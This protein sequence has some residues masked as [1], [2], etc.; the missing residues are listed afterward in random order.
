MLIWLHSGV[1]YVLTWYNFPEYWPHSKWWQNIMELSLIPS[2]QCLDKCCVSYQITIMKPWYRLAFNTVMKPKYVPIAFANLAYAIIKF[3]ILSNIMH[4]HILDL[5]HAICLHNYCLTN[6][7]ISSGFY[8]V[9][10]S[11]N[12]I[13]YQIT[14]CTWKDIY[15]FVINTVLPDSLTPPLISADIMVINFGSR[16]HDDVIKKKHF[17][18]TDPL[19]RESIDHLWIPLTKASGAELWFFICVRTSSWANQ[20]DAGDLRH[21]RAHHDAIV[22]I[23]KTG[24]WMLMFLLCWW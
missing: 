16:A 22:M 15:I 19:W 3:I 13:E 2:W 10:W 24:T 12:S 18:V 11:S 7:K 6:H 20:W 23:C 21:H 17:S 5:Y 1:D 9:I 4:N 8:G 14:K